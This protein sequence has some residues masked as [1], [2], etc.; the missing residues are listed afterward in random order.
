MIGVDTP[1]LL[2]LLEG[3]PEASRLLEDDSGEEFCTTEINLLEL[4][5]A[6]R[7]AGARGRAGHIAA[8]DRLRRKITVFPFD[9]RAA[10][11][12]AALA[13]A[14]RVGTSAS[15]WM[16]LGTLAANGATEVLTTPRSGLHGLASPV[17][18]EEVRGRKSKSRVSR[19]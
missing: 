10:R 9:E 6:A 12:T 4:E 19:K 8:L 7:A 14:Q 2:A 3:K 13:G 15:P 11:A 16:I 18:L 5:V 1:V 17:K